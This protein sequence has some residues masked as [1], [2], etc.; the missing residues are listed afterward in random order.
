MAWRRVG[1]VKAGELFDANLDLAGACRDHPFVQGIASGRLDR[2]SF[3]YFV[4]Q[5]ARFLDVFVRAYALGVARAP[6]REVMVAFKSLLD[7]GFEELG[8]H[9]AYATRWGV[10]LAPEPAAATSAY[11]DF[12]L[13]VAALEPVGH[14][15]AAMT[16]CMRLYAWLG[17][18]LEPVT[19]ADSPYRE[20]VET[21]A[22][23]GFERLAT[24]LEELLD[25]LGGDPA[26]VAGHYRTAMRLELAFFTAAHEQ[27][28]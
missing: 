2:A 21:Y 20:W 4:G 27:A 9:H 13:R 14:M 18:E 15:C 17:R 8:L 24:A 22:G 26:V 12:V 28:P 19:A 16:P 23:P 7:G 5:D 3:C 25:R 11:T 6:D 10:G 1:G